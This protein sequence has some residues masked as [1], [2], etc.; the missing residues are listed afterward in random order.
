MQVT[1]CYKLSRPHGCTALRASN[2][3]LLALSVAA[4]AAGCGGAK[5]AATTAA[6]TTGPAVTAASPATT[7]PADPGAAT[8][9]AYVRAARDGDTAA[10]WRMLSTESQLRLGPTLARFRKGSGAIVADRT[11]AWRHYTVIVSERV[12]SEF[13]VVAIDGSRGAGGRPR[14][15]EAIVLRLEGSRWR[16]ELGSPVRVRLIG[17]DPAG[18]KQVV[19]QVAAAVTGRGGSGTAVMYV[20]GHTVNP[21][22]A[23]TASNS[24]LFA[25]F[26]PPLDPGRHTAVV[27]ATVGRDAAATAWAFTALKG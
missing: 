16:V 11:G 21:A 8:V 20:D 27:F 9:R 26:D 22:V 18:P 6:G 7:A 17:P 25:T 12:T 5:H 2:T 19:Q 4:L 14:A 1:Q 13:G 3:V 10:L 15:V 24:T 23:G